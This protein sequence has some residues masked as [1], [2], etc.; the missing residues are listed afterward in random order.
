MNELYEEVKAKL[1]L[2]NVT[3][4]HIF[5]SN[6]QN[7]EGKQEESLLPTQNVTSNG[8]SKSFNKL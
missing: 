2:K 6:V 5:F 8:V 3:L 1:E 4:E 7:E